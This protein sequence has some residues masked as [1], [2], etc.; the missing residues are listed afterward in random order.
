M[1]ETKY[2]V[3]IDLGTTHCVLAYA[4]TCTDEQPNLPQVMPVQQLVAVGQ[5]TEKSALPSFLY[6]PQSPEF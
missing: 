3:G 6:I 2:C 5:V 1:T 4:E